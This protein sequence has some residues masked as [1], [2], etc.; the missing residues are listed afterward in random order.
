MNLLDRLHPEFRN[1][2][3]TQNIVTGD[4]YMGTLILCD[5]PSSWQVVEWYLC[6]INQRDKHDN[7]KHRWKT[8]DDI[9]RIQELYTPPETYTG[10]ITIDQWWITW[11][12]VKN[13]A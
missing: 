12:E 3:K 13:V 7:R 9:I 8:K 11:Q 4:L 5:E 6:L 2:Y 1:L 10:R